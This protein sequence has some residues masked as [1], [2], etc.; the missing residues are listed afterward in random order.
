MLEVVQQLFG[1]MVKLNLKWGILSSFDL[2]YVAHCQGDFGE[3]LFIS[4][5]IDRL[6][7]RLL[8]VIAYMLRR[9]TEDPDNFQKEGMHCDID[10]Y[11]NSIC[12]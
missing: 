12:Y 6:S 7:K 3:T 4:D 2:T 1:Y 9:A 8:G 10:F 5:G 11:H